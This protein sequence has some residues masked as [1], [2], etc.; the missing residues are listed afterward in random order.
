M[1][2][3][4]VPSTLSAAPQKS[5]SLLGRSVTL[6]QPAPEAYKALCDVLLL[7]KARME[8]HNPPKDGSFYLYPKAAFANFGLRMA[9]PGEFTLK[10]LSDADT[11]IT[12]SI[13][14]RLRLRRNLHAILPVAV[15][16][17]VFGV[18]GLGVSVAVVAAAVCAVMIINPAKRL[19]A[20]TRHL[21]AASDVAEHV[22]AA[23]TQIVVLQTDSAPVAA[24]Q[25]AAGI[26]QRPASPKRK[27]KADNL[28][29]VRNPDISSR[30]RA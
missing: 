30:V 16:G 2:Q 15:A 24:P 25:T 14:P 21:K 26:N 10:P 8:T 18:W 12:I 1:T 29:T 9:Y 13:K 11:R 20:L 5:G 27:K 22:S 19:D 3:K 7:E 4:P 6:N 28:A 23:D 17:A